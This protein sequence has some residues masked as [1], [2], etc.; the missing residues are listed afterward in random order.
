MPTR[1]RIKSPFASPAA[2]ASPHPGARLA[3][4]P[5]TG[6]EEEYLERHLGEPNTARLCNEVLARCAVPPGEEPGAAR[7]Q[8][9]ALLVAERD[10]ELVELR[11]ASLGPHVSAQVPCPA[12]G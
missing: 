12:C 10:R 11:R 7:E 3:L 9:R 5:L 1:E 2:A 8:V 4:R 6:W